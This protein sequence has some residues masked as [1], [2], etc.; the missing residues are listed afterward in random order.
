MPHTIFV[1]YRRADSQHA[2]FAIV[3]RLRWAFGQDQVF[4]DRGSIQGGAD[5]SQSIR[6]AVATARVVLVVIGP[7]WL[8]VTDEWG[9]RRI[10]DPEDWVRQELCVALERA[11]QQQAHLVQVY[12][13]GTP[14]LD[15]R[16]LDGPLKRLP[17]LQR[18]RLSNDHWEAALD[19]LIDL[20]AGHAG[21][22]RL[23][24]EGRF[25][26]GALA[27]PAP[28]Q[29]QRQP[30]DDEQVRARLP[31][32]PGWQLGWSPHPW[33]LNRRAQELSRVYDF[34]SFLSALAFMGRAASAIDGWRPPHH[35]RWENQ[36]KAV[37]VAF[38]T[39]DV[40]CR[41]TELDFEAA[42]RLDRLFL[43]HQRQGG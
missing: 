15:P 16:A 29:G 35:P 34:P 32:L 43:E 31:A 36:W 3:D 33:G 12:L 6:Q 11:T 19:R 1:S 25:P 20:V 22:Q 14:A 42:R 38:S 17:A 9:R 10:D 5:W 18:E 27:R 13:D 2:A 39:W 23:Q 7:D 24:T 28:G 4:F 8:R 26:N 41:I 21:L 30:L 40:G 37:S